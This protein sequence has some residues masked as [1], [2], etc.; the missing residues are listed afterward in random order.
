M[1][2]IIKAVILM[3]SLPFRILPVGVFSKFLGYFVL[4]ANRGGKALIT[5]HVRPTSCELL[6]IDSIWKERNSDV[7]VLVQGPYQSAGLFTLETLR[8][9]RKMFPEAQLVLSTWEN[10]DVKKDLKEI[11]KLCHVV[12]A[13]YPDTSGSHNINLQ[14]STVIAGIRLFKELGVQYCLKTRADQRIYK[15][16]ALTYLKYLIS[17][18]PVPP[19]L[20]A[21]GRI[22]ELSIACCKYRPWSLCDMFQFGYIEDLSRMWNF[23]NDSRNRTA[24]EYSAKPY[25]VIDLVN[26]NVAE[27]LVHRHYAKIIGMSDSASYDAYYAFIRDALVLV[28]KEQLDLFWN[29]YTV[30]EYDWA[31]VPPYDRDQLLSRLSFSDWAMLQSRFFELNPSAFEGKLER[32]EI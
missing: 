22:V 15:N 20:K 28:D 32:Y 4:E 6:K 27:I 3:F 13:D 8:L 16:T 7:G 19:G 30:S 10:S 17:N 2:K 14:K 5:I 23:E 29:K 26:E 31:G 25:R 18:Y 24:A 11:K 1:L 12:F 9:Y 21:N